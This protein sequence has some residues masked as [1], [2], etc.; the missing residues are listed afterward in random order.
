[1]P[2]SILAIVKV[3][4]FQLYTIYVET[5]VIMNKF[6]KKGVGTDELRSYS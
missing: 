6:I 4:Q 2:T 5:P 3:T 1:M